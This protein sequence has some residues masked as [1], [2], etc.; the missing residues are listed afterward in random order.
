MNI[1][2]L[3]F[4][5]IML[6]PII[7]A[8]GMQDLSLLLP[9]SLPGWD[10]IETERI[11]NTESLYDYI[12]GGAE[13][14]LSYGMKEV[15]SR[16]Y[17]QANNSEIRVEIFDMSR[18]GDAF[19]VF[20][21]T[22]TKDEKQYG[23]GSQYFTGALIFWKDRYYISITA[24]DENDTIRKA[25]HSVAKQIDQKIINTGNL[26][27]IVNFLPT[28]L[29][30]EDSYVYFHHYIWLN[31]RYY[32]ADDNF[33]GINDSTQAV[34]AKYEEKNKRSI[35]LLILYP[36][37]TLAAIA[38]QQ[39]ARRFIDSPNDEVSKIED[40]SWLGIRLSGNLLACVFNARSKKEVVDFLDTIQNQ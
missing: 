4:I 28:Q 37:S 5:I 7:S 11:Y 16:I 40:N 6:D 24:N 10:Q 3:I 34:L 39:F 8:A 19:G 17:H 20:S 18:S 35:L 32:I 21:H 26:P 25:I 15:V 30:R 23:Q 22:R 36:D 14:Y 31:S 9:D 38:R 13:L 12:D 33:L 29:A 1:R 2:Q 27:S